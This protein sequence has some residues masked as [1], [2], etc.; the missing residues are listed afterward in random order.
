M[1]KKKNDNPILTDL[2]ER[3][4]KLETNMEWVRETLKRIDSRSWWILGSVVTLGLLA[5]LIALLK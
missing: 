1:S 5:I 3:V 2:K 4:A